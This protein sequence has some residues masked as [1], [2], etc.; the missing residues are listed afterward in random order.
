MLLCLPPRRGGFGLDKPIMNARIDMNGRLSPLSASPY[1]EC[2]LYWPQ[3]KLAVEYDSE[4]EHANGR[5]LS[6]D[7]RKRVDLAARGIT[8]ISLTKQQVLHIPSMEQV[9]REIAHITGKRLR[10]ETCGL[11]DARIELRK[12]LIWDRPK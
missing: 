1:Y 8:V 9:A 5:Q 6:R 11:T 4:L 12:A 10:K 7:A 3:A 2:D